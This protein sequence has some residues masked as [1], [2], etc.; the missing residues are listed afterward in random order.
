MGWI[1]ILLWPALHTGQLRSTLNQ[2]EMHFLQKTWPQRVETGFFQIFL[3]IGQFWDPL[4]ELVGVVGSTVVCPTSLAPSLAPWRLNWFAVGSAETLLV[5]LGWGNLFLLFLLLRWI[6]PER[7][8]FGR[9][10]CNCSFC[11]RCRNISSSSSVSSKTIHSP[12]IS[13]RINP[14]SCNII[15]MFWKKSQA[16]PILFNT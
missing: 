14:V 10:L 6:L 9:P 13:I 16:S 12:A 7:V 1:F 5:L 3:Q 11:K 2:R 8:I 15:P 4:V